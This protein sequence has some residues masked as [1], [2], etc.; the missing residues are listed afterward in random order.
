ML[1]TSR[2]RFNVLSHD[3]DLNPARAVKHRHAPSM[4]RSSCCHWRRVVG[5]MFIEYHSIN[6]NTDP[7]VQR[8][9]V[10]VSL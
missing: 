10:H 9:F 3:P 5:S 1:A 6:A 2:R 7:R 4:L 8:D